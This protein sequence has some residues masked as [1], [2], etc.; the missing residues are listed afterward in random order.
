[1][2]CVFTALLSADTIMY[3]VHRNNAVCY[4]AHTKTG[5]SNIVHELHNVDVAWKVTIFHVL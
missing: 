3:T 5:S 2:V 1:M 4:L